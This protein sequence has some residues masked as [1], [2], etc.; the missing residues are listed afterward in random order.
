MWKTVSWVVTENYLNTR[1]NIVSSWTQRS[2]SG[3]HALYT[4][5]TIPDKRN[6]ATSKILS[7]ISELRSNATDIRSICKHVGVKGAKDVEFEHLTC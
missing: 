5:E 6:V 4:I 7:S 1:R 2:I 3:L